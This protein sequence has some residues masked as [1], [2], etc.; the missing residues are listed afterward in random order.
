MYVDGKPAGTVNLYSS[1]TQYKLKVWDTGPCC[2]RD[3]HT[4]TVKRNGASG[5]GGTNIGLDTFEVIGTPVQAK[6]GTD[7][8]PVSGYGQPHHVDRAM[9]QRGYGIG[10]R[11]LPA[12]DG[13][14]VPPVSP[15]TAL[16]AAACQE[17]PVVRHRQGEGRRCRRRHGPISTARPR[18]TCQTVWS[19]NTLEPGRH[20]VTIE[21]TGD[22]NA[23]ATGTA[24]S[25]DAFDILGTPVKPDGLNR[26]EE[27]DNRLGWTGTWE[28]LPATGPSDGSYLGAKTNGAGV[29]VNFAGRISL[30]WR[31]SARL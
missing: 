11:W 5:G 26:Y 27:T 18:A 15:S 7:G 6:P 21:W 3:T 4:V 17:G 9:G 30:G 20:T 1:T 12:P 28:A 13:E 22:K 29:T 10:L 16:P 8:H 25:L 19:T 24:I 2:L 31:P 23:A 14:A